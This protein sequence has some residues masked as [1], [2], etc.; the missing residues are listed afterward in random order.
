LRVGKPGEARNQAELI[1][2]VDTIAKAKG[3]RTDRK[4]A[5]IYADRGRNLERAIQLISEELRVRQ[6]VYTYDALAWVL[7]RTGQAAK[8]EPAMRKALSL[9]TPEPIFFYHA[10]RILLTL[11][12][13]GEGCLFLRR[14]L[15]LNPEF[16]ITEAKEAQT[17]LRQA[18]R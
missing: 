3:E 15:E 9:G 13:S 11:G 6:D 14:A 17:A 18:Q 12:K 4:L 8:A 5:V 1:D 7:F 2:V 16:D 10:G